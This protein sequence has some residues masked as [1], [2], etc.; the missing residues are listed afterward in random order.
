MFIKLTI[1]LDYIFNFSA[2]VISVF[3]EYYPDK[4]VSR[5]ATRFTDGLFV[6]I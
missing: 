6:H 4:Y 2:F 1:L 5:I 3:I